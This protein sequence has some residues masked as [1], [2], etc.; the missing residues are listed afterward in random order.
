MKLI[1]KFHRIVLFLLVSIIWTGK[2]GTVNQAVT[3]VITPPNVNHG[4]EISLYFTLDNGL[5]PGNFIN[6]ILPSTMGFTVSSATWSSIGL[7][8][9]IPTTYY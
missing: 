1:A 8:T 7:P 9:L 6:V 2:A 3:A 4:K 5:E